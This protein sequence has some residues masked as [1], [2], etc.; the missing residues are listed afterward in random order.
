MSGWGGDWGGAAG[1][2]RGTVK[3]GGGGSGGRPE[4]AE[5]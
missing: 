4:G 2:P 1:S 5:A 3:R